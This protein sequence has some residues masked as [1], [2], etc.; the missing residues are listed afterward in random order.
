MF[1]KSYFMISLNYRGREIKQVDYLSSLNQLVISDGK[2]LIPVSLD[3]NSI[4]SF[5]FNYKILDS[6]KEDFSSILLKDISKNLSEL[7]DLFF[8]NGIYLPERLPLK[9]NLEGSFNYSFCRY[10]IN[11]NFFD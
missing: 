9:N 10:F 2:N 1:C 6:T 11:E 3:E 7:E 4:F 5:G 8:V